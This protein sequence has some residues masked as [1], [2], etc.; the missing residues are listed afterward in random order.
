MNALYHSNVV[1][2]PE[3]HCLAVEKRMVFLL[4]KTALQ[5]APRASFQS[6]IHILKKIAKTGEPNRRS[7]FNPKPELLSDVSAE[8]KC[9]VCTSDDLRDRAPAPCLLPMGMSR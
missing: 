2:I 5:I 7:D 8:V 1:R 3:S 6:I 9:R 4:S